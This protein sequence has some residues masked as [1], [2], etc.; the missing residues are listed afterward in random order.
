MLVD[1]NK[2]CGSEILKFSQILVEIL[3][4]FGTLTDLVQSGQTFFITAN[5]QFHQNF[6]NGQSQNL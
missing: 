2:N 5:N 4:W 3:A 6:R 1:S